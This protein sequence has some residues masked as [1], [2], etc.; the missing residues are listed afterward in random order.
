MIDNIVYKNLFMYYTYLTG[1]YI[2][3]HGKKDAFHVS[4]KV[5]NHEGKWRLIA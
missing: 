2:H 4:Y 3:I 1:L 5:H